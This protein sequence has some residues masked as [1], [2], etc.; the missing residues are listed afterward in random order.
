MFALTNFFRGSVRG[1]FRFVAKDSKMPQFQTDK[2]EPTGVWINVE[3]T[4]QERL[5]TAKVESRFKALQRLTPADRL[6]NV[7]LRRRSRRARYVT[8]TICRELYDSN[9]MEY[10]WTNFAHFYPGVDLETFTKSA[11]EIYRDV[12]RPK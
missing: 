9:D 12:A 10:D 3:R 7:H 6:E 8:H 5:Q 2:I 4:Y 11:A 1:L